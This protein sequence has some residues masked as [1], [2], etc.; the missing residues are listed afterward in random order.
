VCSRSPE[1][2]PAGAGCGCGTDPGAGIA[3]CPEQLCNPTAEM[4]FIFPCFLKKTTQNPKPNNPPPTH[5]SSARF[6][7]SDD[8]LI[9]IPG[10]NST[11]L[12]QKRFASSEAFA[13]R[14]PGA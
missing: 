5:A 4:S 8:L 2:D 7:L 1:E 9:W 3:P 14:F 12:S 13:L 10:T 11:S 6:N